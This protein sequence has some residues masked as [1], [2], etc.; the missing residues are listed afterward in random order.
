MNDFKL[1]PKFT[2]HAT[3]RSIQRKISYLDIS[4]ILTYGTFIHRQN[5]KFYYLVS[6]AIPEG[7]ELN[8]RITSIIVITSL[9]NEVITC[10]FNKRPRK[11]ISK[12][13][14]RYSGIYKNKKYSNAVPVD[15]IQLYRQGLLKVA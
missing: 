14:K 12:K 13:Q 3:K 5:R 11:H 15:Q 7:V 1:Q 10:Y 2:E 9:D 6:K 4:T 8:D